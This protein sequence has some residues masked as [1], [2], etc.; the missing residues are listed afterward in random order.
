M[1]PNAFVLRQLHPCVTGPTVA[2]L[3]S[4][5]WDV[6]H[7]PV[8]ATT[9]LAGPLRNALSTPTGTRLTR[10]LL[11]MV[12][13]YQ[14]VN[15]FLR[16]GILVTDISKGPSGAQRG[17][18]IAGEEGSPAFMCLVFTHLIWSRHEADVRSAQSELQKQANDDSIAISG[19]PTLGTALSAAHPSSVDASSFEAKYDPPKKTRYDCLHEE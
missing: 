4:R 1:H 12:Q 18:S 13:P 15:E 19:T 9:M 17:R 8:D 10:A 7:G 5:Y 3:D 2:R 11:P 14:P 16:R 6:L